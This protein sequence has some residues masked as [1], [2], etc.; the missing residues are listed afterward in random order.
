MAATGQQHRPFSRAFRLLCTALTCLLLL[1]SALSIPP[2]ASAASILV[3]TGTL[4][5]VGQSSVPVEKDC[6]KRAVAGKIVSFDGAGLDHACIPAETAH[7]FDGP[8]AILAVFAPFRPRNGGLDAR[9]ARAPPAE[10]A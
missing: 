2:A 6:R 3:R 4:K 9:G 1:V 10:F 7:R 5:T 8:R